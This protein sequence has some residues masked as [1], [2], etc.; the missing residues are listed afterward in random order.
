MILFVGSEER[1]YFLEESAKMKQMKVE[2]LGNAM[3]IEAHLTAILEKTMQYLVIDIEQYIDK[4]DELAT[5]IESIKRAKNC[6][7]IIYAPGYVRESRCE[8]RI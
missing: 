2:Y 5:K 1:G 4:A 7:V 3:S 8:R 6:D